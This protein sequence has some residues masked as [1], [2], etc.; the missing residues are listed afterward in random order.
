M[1]KKTKKKLIFYSK[2]KNPKG[3]KNEKKQ[4]KQIKKQKNRRRKS[5]SFTVDCTGQSTV[6][7]EPF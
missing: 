6:K 3:I 1:K 4:K 2:T 5:S 7:T